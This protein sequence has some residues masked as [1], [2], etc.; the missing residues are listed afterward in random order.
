M[1]L[2]KVIPVSRGTFKKKTSSGEFEVIEQLGK[3]LFR[4]SEVNNKLTIIK[5]IKGGKYDSNQ[6]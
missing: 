1:K 2:A 4:V 5:I 6:N 3:G